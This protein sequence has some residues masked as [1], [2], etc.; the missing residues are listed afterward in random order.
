[1]A[2]Q[3]LL[4]AD[5]VTKVELSSDWAEFG[6]D[7]ERQ[8]VSELAKTESVFRPFPGETC[9]SQ[10]QSEAFL[11]GRTPHQY[12]YQFVMEET[13]QLRAIFELGDGVRVNR[14][15]ADLIRLTRKDTGELEFTVIDIKASQ[16][17]TIFHRAQIAFY[18]LTLRAWILALWCPR[19][20]LSRGVAFGP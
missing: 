8:L 3:L 16:V 1:M 18:A 6:N 5:R 9:L 13:P 7:F 12:A 2:H 15:I 10:K 11:S 17:P 20:R 14:S 19:G 4:H